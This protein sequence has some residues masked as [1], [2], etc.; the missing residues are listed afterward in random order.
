VG[1]GASSGGS[2]GGTTSG[3]VSGSAKPECPDPGSGQG[4][5]PDPRSDT[6]GALSADGTIFLLFGGDTATAVCG[7]VPSHTHVGDTWLLDTACGG[8]TKFDVPAPSARSRHS[9]ALDAKGGRA[10]LFGGRFRAGNSGNYTLYKDVWAFDFATKTWSEV[11]TTGTG[12]SER[13]NAAAAVVDGKLV[14]YGGNSSKSGLSFTPL[15]DLFVLD[16]ATGEWSQVKAPGAPK[17]RLFH[18]MAGHPSKNVVYVHSGGDANAF[19]GPFFKDTWS[20]DLDA[21]AW[22]QVSDKTPDDTGRIKHGMWATVPEGAADPELF[23]FAGHD[24]GQLGNRDDVLSAK[25]SGATGTFEAV[26]PGDTFNKAGS[27]QCN[28]PPDFTTIDKESPERRSGFAIGALPDGSA[29]VVFGG[30]SDCGVLS[31]AQ[32]Y[33]ARESTWTPIRAT[34]P[35]L[36]CLRT[37]SSTCTSLCN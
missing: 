11:K 34:L 5:T 19:V 16:L 12:P 14:V 13:C 1:S 21:G 8:W 22:T 31:D 29:A 37:G 17:A 27:G 23:V 20:F 9:M 28:F 18:A 30:A 4:A 33:D 15:G 7:D 2:G 6:A 24:D 32:W 26:R 35:G 25:L 3:N 10:L 36:V